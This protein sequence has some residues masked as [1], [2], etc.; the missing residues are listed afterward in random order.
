M[1]TVDV[2]PPIVRA[3][4]LVALFALG[5]AAGWLAA[6]Q[7][8]QL[9]RAEHAQE[10][11]LLAAQASAARALAIQNARDTERHYQDKLNEANHAHARALAQSDDDLRRAYAELDRLRQHVTATAARGMSADSA[12]AAC[13]CAAATEL[14]AECAGRLVDVAG[15]ADRHA[16]DAAHLY[17]AWPTIAKGGGQ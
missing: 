13:D 3:L 8:L 4:A 2:F 9:E 6:S 16:A 17:N 7:R 1:I 14:L 15:A 5:C 11:S 10:L 12:A